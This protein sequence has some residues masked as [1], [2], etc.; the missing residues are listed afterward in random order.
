MTQ[1]SASFDATIRFS[2]GGDLTAHGFRVDLPSRAVDEAEIAALFVASLGLLMTDSVEL[3][4][5]EIFAEPHKGTRGGLSDHG[6]GLAAGG[7]E[8]AQHPRA[9]RQSR[10]Q[11]ASACSCQPGPV[12]LAAAGLTQ[13]VPRIWLSV[14]D[15]Y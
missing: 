13:L 1:Y 15:R 10:R 11:R 4:N 6:R 12:A 14:R 9:L 3:G 8:L 5:V 7:G 2:N